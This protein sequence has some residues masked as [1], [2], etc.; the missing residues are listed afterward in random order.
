MVCRMSPDVFRSVDWV[1]FLLSVR[2]GFATALI[3]VPIGIGMGYWLAFTRTRMRYLVEWVTNL[4]LVLPPTVAGFYLLM[5]VGPQSSIGSW[6]SS[7]WGIHVAF[8]FEGILLASVLF[9]L[10]FMVSA[11][12]SGFEDLPSCWR[13]QSFL[14]GRSEGYTL[15][16]VLLPNMRSSIVQ[17]FAL[18]FARTLGEFGIVMMIGGNLPG[19]TEVV[20]ISIY[21]KVEAFRYDEAHVYSLILVLISVVLLGI[22]S[23]I[24]SLWRSRRENR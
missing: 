6:L 21:N 2:L 22:V 15:I 20:S 17:G 10:P 18:C 8:S 16:R 9:N 23:G 1:P 5:M 13:E 4:P 3:L 14:L 7:R 24:D 19:V 11:V 12:R